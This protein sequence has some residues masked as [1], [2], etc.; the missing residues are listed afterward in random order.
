[1]DQEDPPV[2]ILQSSINADKKRNFFEIQG[3]HAK[4]IKLPPGG[5]GWGWDSTM[6]GEVHGKIEDF[7]NQPF[8]VTGE[9]DF[10]RHNA[11]CLGAPFDQ[12]RKEA[13]DALANFPV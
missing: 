12:M 13:A 8:V 5:P 2:V 1:M 3:N 11:L 7:D 6:D 9:T 10:A 4:F